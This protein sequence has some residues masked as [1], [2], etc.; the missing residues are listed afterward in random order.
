MREGKHTQNEFGAQRFGCVAR[1]H[2]VGGGLLPESPFSQGLVFPSSRRSNVCTTTLLLYFSPQGPL[3]TQ[4]FPNI[5][6]GG[7]RRRGKCADVGLWTHNVTTIK[8][9]LRSS[10][11]LFCDEE[12]KGG[13][14]QN[15]KKKSHTKV[16]SSDDSSATTNLLFCRSEIFFFIII[17]LPSEVLASDVLLFPRRG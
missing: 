9:F 8:A 13:T 6:A 4:Q 2:Q 12:K 14:L 15:K 5:D 17:G 3:Q 10:T 16:T 1:E 11:L 7:G